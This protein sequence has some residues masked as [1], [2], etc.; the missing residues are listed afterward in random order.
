M[1]PGGS[2]VL[3]SW[4]EKPLVKVACRTEP[5]GLVS[6]CD[7]EILGGKISADNLEKRLSAIYSHSDADNNWNFTRFQYNS[8]QYLHALFVYINKRYDANAEPLRHSNCE[9]LNGL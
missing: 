5:V 2:S 1:C 9:P 7:N 3:L 8:F 6:V 4:A